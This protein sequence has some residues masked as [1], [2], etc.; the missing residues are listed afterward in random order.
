MDPNEIVRLRNHAIVLLEC[1]TTSPEGFVLLYIAWEG[2][3]RRILR[4]GLAA[5]GMNKTSANTFLRD[6][7][8]SSRDGIANA[9]VDVYEIKPQSLRGV[10][11]LLRDLPKVNELRHRYVHGR[12]NTSPEKFDAMARVLLQLLDADWQVALSTQLNRIGFS[13]KNSD[14]LKRIIAAKRK[15]LT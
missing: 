13:N 11:H 6:A 2:L 5:K 14:P 9:F 4:V 8:L 10:G 12:G 15:Y 3:V 7:R 1:P